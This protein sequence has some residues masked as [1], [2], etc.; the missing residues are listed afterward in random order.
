M[1]RTEERLADALQAS[2]GQVRNDRLRPLPEPK[3][4]LSAEPGP[5]TGTRP[6]RA[7]WRG[8]LVPLA[9]AASVA[10]VIGV[11]LALASVPGRLA[12]PP[13]ASR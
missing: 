8:W 13:P 10:L 1:T 6:V 2:A 11:A 9:A 3:P 5:G 12:G 4:G 7:A